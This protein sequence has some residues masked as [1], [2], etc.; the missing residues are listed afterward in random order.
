[1]SW[2]EVIASEDVASEEIAP[3]LSRPR[4]TAVNCPHR[5]RVLRQLLE[6][7]LFEQIVP[8]RFDGRYFSFHIAGQAYRARGRLSGFGR[9][10]GQEALYSYVRTKNVAIRVAGE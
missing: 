9:E 6:A 2:P 7:V 4:Q 8:Y 5:A 3:E 1:M 10:K